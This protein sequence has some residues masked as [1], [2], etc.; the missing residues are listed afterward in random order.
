MEISIIILTINNEYFVSTLLDS[1]KKYKV[2]EKAEIILIDSSGKKPAITSFQNFIIRR[3]KFVNLIITDKIS[4]GKARNRGFKEAKGNIIVYLDSDTELTK[5]WYEALVKSMICSDIV[6]GYSPDPNMRDIGRVPTLIDGHDITFATCNIAYKRKVFEKVGG[7]IE[8]QRIPEDCEFHY[9][10]IKAGFAI[11]YNPK[12]KVLHHQRFSTFGFL[13]Q[14]FWNG[15]ARYELNKLYPDIKHAHQ[16][17]LSF[18]NI[19]RMGAGF[20]GFTIGRFLGKKDKV[21]ARYRK[22]ERK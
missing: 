21:G 19:L 17:G 5:G 8:I 4:K 11:D 14:A 18:N 20:L 6:A 10:C 3:Y 1:I 22:E 7:F 12:M 13:K 16:H 2:H 9:R 15:E